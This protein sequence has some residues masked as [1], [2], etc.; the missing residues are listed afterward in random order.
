[1]A[2]RRGA[3]R[4]DT[5]KTLTISPKSSSSLAIKQHIK[6]NQ[7]CHRRD[8]IAFRWSRLRLNEVEWDWRRLD[9]EERWSMIGRR[10]TQLAFQ[11][12]LCERYD[13]ERRSR[14]IR[15]LHVGIHTKTE[16]LVEFNFPPLFHT[17][18]PCTQYWSR[19]YLP[20]SSCFDIIVKTAARQHQ[21]QQ[22]HT[23]ASCVDI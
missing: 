13:F 6:S 14:S 8:G 4:Y 23:I 1:M 7:H 22:R 16:K 15:H 17:S 2:V 19:S 11:L 3:G 5:V 9:E 21:L 18:E 10:S 12:M 20:S